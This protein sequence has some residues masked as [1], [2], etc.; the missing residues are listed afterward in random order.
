MGSKF[1]LVNK[2]LGLEYVGLAII[3]LMP[4][5]SRSCEKMVLR[6]TNNDDVSSHSDKQGFF[7]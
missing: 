4:F 2:L 6:T 5:G 7:F 1:F 3:I